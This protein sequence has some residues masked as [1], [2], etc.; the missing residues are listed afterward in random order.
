MGMFALGLEYVWLVFDM[1]LDAAPK[2]YWM[3]FNSLV[4]RND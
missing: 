2:S 4:K 1:I 3:M